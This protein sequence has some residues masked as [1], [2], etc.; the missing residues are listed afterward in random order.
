MFL[1]IVWLAAC[2][3]VGGLASRRN[4]SFV[5]WTTLSFFLSPLLGVLFLIAA[6]PKPAKVLE[7]PPKR[8]PLEAMTR[9]S[10]E[11]EPVTILDRIE[12]GRRTV[13]NSSWGF[14]IFLLVIGAGLVWLTLHLAHQ[15][16]ESRAELA[17]GQDPATAPYVS[18][19]GLLKLWQ[20]QPQRELVIVP[21]PD[22]AAQ[23]II[24]DRTARADAPLVPLVP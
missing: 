16:Q 12:D 23:G 13:R 2:M 20:E 22:P 5:G 19:H 8:D 21:E 3:A 15:E 24:L 9:P 11:P 18:G 14:P 1:V 4:R 17:A 7:L 6:G 10:F